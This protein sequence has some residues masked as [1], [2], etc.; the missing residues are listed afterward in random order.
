LTPETVAPR[1]ALHAVRAGT[2][3]TLLL[4]HG[5][6]S[7]ATS[8]QRQFARLADDYT[9]IAP[10]LRGYGDSPDPSGAPSLD[11]VA[12]DLAALV[13]GAAVHV[14]GVS[15]G[16]L[17]ALAL[18]RRH[19]GL[20]RSLVLSD[21]TL[22]RATLAPAELTRWVEGRY[23]LAAGLQERAAERAREIAGP[24]APADVLAE[25]ASNMRRA[26]PAGYRYVTD[27]IAATD[28]LPWLDDVAVPT[29]VVCGEHDGVVGLALS[30]TIAERIPDARLATIPAA[31]HAPNLERPDEFAEAVRA[32][33][34]G[35]ELPSRV[36]RVA[37]AG[38]GAIA[39]VLIDG[40]AR[41]SG[42][43]ARVTAI[44]RLDAEAAGVDVRAR[45]QS[46]AAFADLERLP[47]HAAL[48]IEA[49]GPAVVRQYAAG[50]LARGAD[51]MVLSA[52]AL[53]D[54]VFARELRAVA[55]AHGRR[56]L[57][58]SGA[59]AGIDGIRAG[60]LGGLT[61]L[62]LRTTKPPR[63]LAGAPHVVANAIDLD[64]LTAPAT[65]FEGNVADAVRGFPS[66]VNVAAVLSLA[67]AGVDV[68]VSVV[69]DPA[70]TTN[71]HEIEATGDFGTFTVRLDNLPSP[72]NPKT[73]AL[74]PL[75]ALAM[76]R[77]LSQSMWVGA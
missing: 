65:I 33:V 12:D 59:V 42:G 25:I 16:A 61:S 76:L 23:E 19:P 1:S 60:A 11:A 10:D 39:T 50:W 7:S 43:T 4:L 6:G 56:I 21:T 31:G 66:N 71:T 8:W 48:V 20:V 26:R 57:V 32:F 30:Q 15:F 34:D 53:I 24:S 54:P 70:S 40:I 2:G 74:A 14:V 22:G 64:A 38:A 47:D 73:S 27:I 45:R 67:G 5:I 77:R 52:G 41:G 36:V 3:P 55:R 29:L 13:N 37:L 69:A 75:S 44:G 72:A 35:V 9:L 28:A 18:A 62:R 49:A 17:A 68:R 63:G 51:V 58:P 46:A